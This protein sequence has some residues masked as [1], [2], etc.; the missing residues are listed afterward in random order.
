MWLE[1]KWVEIIP[2]N[3]VKVDF[4]I[5]GVWWAFSIYENILEIGKGAV[6]SE[7]EIINIPGK[8]K[9]ITES[10][11]IPFTP[12][13]FPPIRLVRNTRV[14]VRTADSYTGSTDHFVKVICAA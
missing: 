9:R 13:F 1:G 6:G 10:G 7:I 3:V 5:I 4:F 11:Y 2:A 14:S 8:R 12:I